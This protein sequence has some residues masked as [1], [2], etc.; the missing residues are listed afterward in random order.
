M[1]YIYIDNLRCPTNS[2]SGSSF[3]EGGS[4]VAEWLIHSIYCFLP[5]LYCVIPVLNCIVP[6]LYC[7]MS[8]YVRILNIIIGFVSRGSIT[9]IL[10]TTPSQCCLLPFYTI[11]IIFHLL[12][13]II[14][15]NPKHPTRP[16][17]RS[18]G[19]LHY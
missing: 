4:D 3:L 1:I 9:H 13:V 19:S 15:T 14:L 16:H 18:I 6:V 2:T 12:V 5:L 7:V 17:S 10:C 8:V 11:P